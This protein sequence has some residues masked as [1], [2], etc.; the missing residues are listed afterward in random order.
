MPIAKPKIT[1]GH[2]EELLADDVGQLWAQATVL[3][4]LPPVAGLRAPAIEVKVIALA[5]TEAV[6]LNAVVVRWCDSRRAARS[7][8]CSSRLQPLASSPRAYRA[9]LINGRADFGTRR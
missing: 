3:I 9:T 8:M 1:I 6:S 4:N 2:V 5:R 7:S